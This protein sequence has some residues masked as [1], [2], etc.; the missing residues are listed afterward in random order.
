MR[1]LYIDGGVRTL[2]AEPLWVRHGRQGEH[3]RV[4]QPG[5]RDAP[6]SAWH[7]RR[8]SGRGTVPHRDGAGLVEER[9]LRI[10]GTGF[11]GVFWSRRGRASVS[12]LRVRE[13]DESSSSVPRSL[14]SLD[15]PASSTT[16]GRPRCSYS[17]LSPLTHTPR[18][19]W[20]KIK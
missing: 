1:L 15:R 18:S 5:T 2:I 11:L 8:S 14:C 3:G 9:I 19:T 7:G 10:V 6:P 17:Q 13:R 4:E 12:M 20:E 16:R